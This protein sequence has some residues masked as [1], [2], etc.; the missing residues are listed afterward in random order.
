M[1]EFSEST[2][3]ERIS[4][5]YDELYSAYNESAI[6]VLCEFGSGG[7][8]LELGIGTGRIALPLKRKGIEVSGIDASEDMVSKLKAKPGGED[9][10]VTI[11]NLAEIDVEGQFKLIFVVFNTFYN[12]QTQEEQI[13]CFKNVARHLTSDGVFLIEAFVPDMTRFIDRQSVRLIDLDEDKARIDL[14]QLDKVNQ[15]VVSQHL[16]LSEKGVKFYPVKLRYA[17]PSEFDLMAQLAG[18]RLL[19]RWGDWGR[20]PFTNDSG[21]HIS[22]YGF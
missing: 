2:Y 22:V 19:H 7:R 11:G 16:S 8:A 12:L 20:D 15:T 21:R 3:G 4:A 6:E 13:R 1:K 10:R 14:A 18:L 17:W 9:I 5:V